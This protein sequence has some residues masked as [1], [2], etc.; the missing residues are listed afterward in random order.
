MFCTGSYLTLMYVWLVSSSSIDS[1]GAA[2]SNESVVHKSLLQDYLPILTEKGK[3]VQDNFCVRGLDGRRRTS[4]WRYNDQVFPGLADVFGSQDAHVISILNLRSEVCSTCRNTLWSSATWTCSFL[5]ANNGHK[6]KATGH[7]IARDPHRLSLVVKCAIPAAAQTRNMSLTGATRNHT[8]HYPDITYCSYDQSKDN[9]PYFLTACTQVN[10]QFSHLL[11]EWVAY[12]QR[13]GFQ[14]FYIYANGHG[15]HVRWLMHP[16]VRTGIVDIIDWD[17]PSPR[18]ATFVHQVSQENSCIQRF[19]RR[20]KWVGLMDVDEFFHT[21]GGNNGATVASWLHSQSET[22][23]HGGFQ[24]QSCFWGSA[25]EQSEQARL[26]VLSPSTLGRYKFRAPAAETDSRQKCIV[27]PDNVYYFSVH[28]IT[29]GGTMLQPD[30]N[31]DIRVAHFKLPSQHVY[32]VYDSSL[33]QW[34]SVVEQDLQLM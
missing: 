3:A 34:A 18:G 7:A 24:V 17:L 1:L 27:R 8:A 6:L 25:T 21:A 14:H 15:R 10:A 20:S 32:D 12:H 13:Q 11:P 4:Y 31:S 28:M 22:N 29:S 30:P 19:A 9:H 2:G 16:F 5:D 33:S 23:I 26:D